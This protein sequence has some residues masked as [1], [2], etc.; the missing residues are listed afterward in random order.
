MS[1][2]IDRTA[3]IKNYHDRVFNCFFC[4]DRARALVLLYH[5]YDPLSYQLAVFVKLCAVCQDRSV[6]RKGHS[7]SLG[8]DMHGVCRSKAGAYSRSRDRVVRHIHQLFK[9]L[10]SA[11]YGADSFIYI[12]NVYKLSRHAL[13]SQL[14]SAGKDDTWHIQSG[15]RH[16]MSRRSLIAGGKK[17][18]PVQYGSLYHAFYFIYDQISRRHKIA[19]FFSC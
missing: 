4:D 2:C 12:V 1:Y 13:A 15:C 17:Y 8:N 5:F 11:G 18:D 16:T 6:S 10:G 19:G 9:S 3:D 7:Q 14:I